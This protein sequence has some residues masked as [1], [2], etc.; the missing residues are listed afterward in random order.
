MSLRGLPENFSVILIVSEMV[1][2]SIYLF[3]D[4][5]LCQLNKILKTDRL[6]LSRAVEINKS[7]VDPGTSIA[8]YIFWGRSLA[9]VTNR[10]RKGDDFTNS[11]IQ[12]H[13]EQ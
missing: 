5:R 13:N 7:S 1:G 4:M 8:Q 6:R 3:C 12:H 9:E 11:S 10:V 2:E